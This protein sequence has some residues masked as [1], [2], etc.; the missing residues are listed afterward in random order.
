MQ[1]IKLSAIDSTND[2]LKELSK[3]DGLENFTTVVAEMQT[4]GKGQM[5][6][7][8]VSEK[9]KNLIMS[10]LI[11]EIVKNSE[12]VFHLNVAVAVSIIEVLQNLNLPNLA[13]K[14]PNDI[15]SDE[16]KVAGILIENRFKSHTK[17]ESVVG[18]GLNVNQTDFTSFPKASSLA[19][20][21]KKEFDREQLLELIVI[22]I[23]QN[24]VLINSNSSKN[25]W[26]QY[27]S[28]LFKKDIEMPF[29]DNNNN[30]LFSGTIL[31][32]TRDGKLEVILQDK[33][34][35]TFGIKELQMQY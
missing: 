20:L 14:W 18:I 12:E 31:G 11:K 29:K 21:M 6:A 5:G 15:L 32:V 24:C 19:L 7:S 23:K 34:I 25:L 8:W 22:K 1:L 13:I 30:N 28:Y 9:G 16:K 26:K 35:K 17:I 2:Y 33:S 4:K 3:Q 10:V 27:F